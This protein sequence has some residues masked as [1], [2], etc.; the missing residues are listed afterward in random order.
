MFIIKII[1]RNHLNFSNS[2]PSL[3]VICRISCIFVVTHP[4]MIYCGK[5][6]IGFSMNHWCNKLL[7]PCRMTEP[8]SQLI[9]TVISVH[10]DRDVFRI[11]AVLVGNVVIQLRIHDFPAVEFEGDQEWD[12]RNHGDGMFPVV[13]YKN[14]CENDDVRE[15]GCKK[16][17]IEKN[18]LS[19]PIRKRESTLHIAPP[20]SLRVK[21][22]YIMSY[23]CTA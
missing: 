2:G 20:V 1:F 21:Y 4:S 19:D 12:G 5:Q 15:S 18:L 9:T 17:T 6:E 16:K 13:I 22:T 3:S 8:V 11:H 7:G 10:R 23:L 14:D